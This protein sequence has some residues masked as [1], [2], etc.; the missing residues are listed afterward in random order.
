MGRP[1]KCWDH[2]HRSHQVGQRWDRGVWPPNLHSIVHW[3][4]GL[5]LLQC[6]KSLFTWAALPV[7]AE[8]ER[9]VLGW[10]L[11]RQGMHLP[12]YSN[13]SH[14]SPV[15]DAAITPT[16][17]AEVMI[18][19]HIL[20]TPKLSYLQDYM[21]FDWICPL[22]HICATPQGTGQP[23]ALPEPKSVCFLGGRLNG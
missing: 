4:L 15:A 10:Y 3:H 5:Y 18:V 7:L 9:I 14:K 1:Q 19:K 8:T 17:H 2:L 20:T 23:K 13:F 16:L 21:P 6:K 11:S 12:G 22:S